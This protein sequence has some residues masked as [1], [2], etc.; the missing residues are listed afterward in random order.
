VYELSA[1]AFSVQGAQSAMSEPIRIAAQQPGYIR[2]GALIVS[3]LSII[4]PL[5]GMTVLL[6][7]LLWWLAISTRRLRRRISLESK[8]A[9]EILQKEFSNL[10]V[11]VT[12]QTEALAALKR[13]KKLT[14]A[15]AAVFTSLQNDL[16]VAE[17]K[18]LKEIT[19]VGTLIKSK[20]KS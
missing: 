16:R 9:E 11:T 18:I 12:K 4:V 6:V 10:Q 13:A 19:D 3:V 8:E 20:N 2:V 14:E 17:K 7:L 1:Q 15:E 5:I